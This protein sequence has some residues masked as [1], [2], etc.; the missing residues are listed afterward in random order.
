MNTNA[1]PSKKSI[2]LIAGPTASGKSALAVRLA[3]IANGVVINADASQVYADLRI[4]SARPDETE[5]ARA[6]HR[7][8]GYRDAA[9]ACTAADWA[10]DARHEIALAQDAGQLPIIVGGTGLYMRTL[11]YGIAPV[12]EID[13]A[14]RAEVR[15]MSVGRAA[16]MLRR[17]DPETAARLKPQDITRISRA[18][19]VIRST[20]RS[21]SV[22]QQELSG[23]II[24]QVS[25][26]PAILL[27][28][29]EWLYARC[30]ARFE[31]ML[32]QGAIEEVEA[33]RTRQ[34]DPSLPAMRAIGVRDII[35][36]CEG[37]TLRVDMVERAQAATRQYAKR[38]YTWFRHQLPADWLRS[39]A[40]LDDNNI[41]EFAIKLRYMALTE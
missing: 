28:P 32:A 30:N 2:A 10:E 36:W 4:L 6:P 24:D 3:E 35:D 22:W 8:F 37:N 18:L 23:G 38:Q 19:E 13:P 15:A 1:S 12:P 5:M 25:I 17:E 21:L 40:Q 33:L 27:P 29:R 41:E 9:T 34:L 39:E 31:T 11:L 20:G 7:L 16:V 14:I 26:A